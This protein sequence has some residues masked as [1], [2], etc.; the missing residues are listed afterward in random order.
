M[1]TE[2]ACRVASTTDDPDLLAF[3]SAAQTLFQLAQANGWPFSLAAIIPVATPEGGR[4]VAAP[5]ALG[6]MRTANI[7]EATGHM[8]LPSGLG[9][10]MALQAYGQCAALMADVL[11]GYKK[12]CEAGG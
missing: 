9:A 11:E 12:A 10:A 7:A 4:G 6:N 8:G 1:P 2:N 5:H 3:Q